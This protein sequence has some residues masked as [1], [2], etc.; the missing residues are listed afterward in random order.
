MIP[1]SPTA[2]P[3]LFPDIASRA[4]QIS[5]QFKNLYGGTCR[6]YRAPGRVNLIGEHTDY[7]DGFVMPAA[8]DFD[9][10]IAISARGGNTFTVHSANLDETREFDLG[11][12][13]PRHDWSDY[14]QGVAVMLRESGRP[15]GGAKILIFSNVPMGGGLSSSAALEVAVGYALLDTQDLPPNLL[16]LALACQ[17]A[18]N[19]FVGARCGIMDQ[20]VA[21]YGKA[22]HA[23]LLDCRSLQ[24]RLLPIPKE[25]RLVIC[26]T[27][28]RHEISAGEYNVRRS[29]CEEGVRLLATALPGV[30]ALRDITVKNF[31]QHREK[32]PL[33]LQK[34]CR[35]VI[36]ENERVLSAGSALEQ[37]DLRSFGALM[38][39]S[40]KSLRDDYEVSCSE[41]DL[42][43]ELALETE[44]VYGARMT[45]GGFGGC[46]VNL[47]A[48]EAVAEFQRRLAVAY[49][50]RVGIVPEIYVSTPSQG[51]GRVETPQ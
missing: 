30:T 28:V 21:C 42:M 23:M 8:I 34:R 50:A 36:A 17:R 3:P 22:E 40:H 38:L 12:P 18:E 29:Q 4:R 15:V 20:F 31:E 37:H 46:T 43:V 48:S 32:L 7:N 33:T 14:I 1:G 9:C 44:G 47:V 13:Q 2:N 5:G 41:L 51:V 16:Q 27:M 35:H 19:E 6:L 26:N 10:W 25:T 39:E 11:S 49:Y 24:H 45:G